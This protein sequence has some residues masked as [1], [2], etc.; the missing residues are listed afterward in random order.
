[1]K[2]PLHIAF[3]LFIFTVVA[4]AQQTGVK[5]NP[6]TGLP[7]DGSPLPKIDPATG[8][9]HSDL[10]DE[11]QKAKALMTLGQYQDSLNAFTNYFERSRFDQGQAGGRL[12][13]V[14]DWMELGRR[15]PKAKQALLDLRDSDAKELLSGD[16][17]FIY[18]AEVNL[19]NQELGKDEATYKLFKAIEQL[20]PHLAGQCYGLIEDQLAQRGE[21]AT[22]RKYMGDPESGFQSDCDRYHMEM[23]NQARMA[24]M[25]KKVQQRMQEFYREHPEIPPPQDY[26]Q[27]NEKMVKDRFVGGVRQLI[28][29]L[30][31]TGDKAE[32]ETIQKEAVA[33]LDDPRLETAVDD[34]KAKV[35]KIQ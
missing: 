29:I 6:A 30:V 12:F 3:L 25:R 14:G 23:D 24:E 15:Y 1:M 9:P 34:A 11:W 33:F 7:D 13:A 2:T 8:L 21:Y 5:I 22:C 17:D 27:R 4:L 35:A 20:D 32:A 28:L 19:I 31:G 16:G 26:S 10:S 18:F